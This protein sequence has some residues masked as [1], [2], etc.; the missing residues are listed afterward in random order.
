MASTLK[1]IL[2]LAELTTQRLTD[3]R[4]NW[5]HFLK[6]AGWNYKYAFHDQVLIHAQKP[7]ATACA[8]LEL[9]NKR[10]RRWV[11]KNAEGIAL[12][13]DTHNKLRLRYVFDISD[14]NS[15]YGYEV[16][17]WQLRE[18][19]HSGV[20][21]ALANSFGDL[22][23]PADMP[24]ALIAAAKNAAEDNYAD[25]LAEL[26]TIKV[27]SFLEELDDFNV[28]VEFR[29]T[30]ETSI[31]YMLLTRCGYDA[32]LYLTAEDFPHLYDFNTIPTITLLGTASSDISEML[33]REIER[34]VRSLER[35]EKN[36]G[37]KFAKEKTADNN[38]SED[39]NIQHDTERSVEYGTDIQTGGRLQTAGADLAGGT[40]GDRE[41]RQD[42]QSVSESAPESTLLHADDD[43]Q[44]DDA[45]GGNR[46]DSA[47]AAGGDYERDGDAGRR[48]GGTESHGSDEVGRSEEQH[49]AS[50]G[51]TD[52]PRTDI[53]LNT[54]QGGD[55]AETS[56]PPFVSEELI[57]ELLS[58]D[59]YLKAKRPQIIQYFREN[60]DADA[61]S[62]YIKSVYNDDYSE[63]L[64]LDKQR[65]GYKK[66]EHG[67]CMWE[68]SYL[69]RTSESVFSWDAV[70]EYIAGLI[71]RN[72]YFPTQPLPTLKGVAE[73]MSLF[74]M[75][76]FEMPEAEATPAPRKPAFTVSQQVIDEVLASGGN[77]S[78]SRLRICAYFKKNHRIG[79]TAVFLQ[80]EFGS[81]GKGFYIGA[82]RITARYEPQGIRIAQGRTAI[83]ARESIVVTWEQAAERIRTLLNAGQYMPQEELDRVDEWERQDIAKRIWNLYRDEF[84]N[85]PD[86][87]KAI[88][89][90]YPYPD[91]VEL[92][93]SGLTNHSTVRII[94]DNIRDLIP[95]MEQYPPRHRIYHDPVEVYNAVSDL[96]LPQPEYKAMADFTFAENRRYISDDEIDALLASRGSGISGGK[97]RIYTYFKNPHTDKEK[98]DFL[99][100]EYGTGGT[101]NGGDNT[102]HDSK[103]LSYSR[104]EL[105]KP[106]DK[107]LLPWNKVAKR[108]EKLIADGR[109]LSREALENYPEY[110][111]LILCREIYNFFSH[112]PEEVPRPYQQGEDF[113]SA[114]KTIRPQLDDRQAV[115]QILATMESVL[116]NTA[117][118]DRHYDLMQ[119]AF[120]DLTA[121]DNG[122]YALIGTRNESPYPVQEQD[123]DLGYGHLGN[124]LTVWDR[125]REVDGDYMTIA[126]IDADRTVTFYDKDLP[127][128]IK[129]EIE[130]VAATAELT[131]SQTQDAPVFS[132]P[133]LSKPEQ[134]QEPE[135]V[136]EPEQT[137]NNGR[138]TAELREADEDSA[139]YA[140]Y[141]SIQN[142]D[143]V[144]DEYVKTFRSLE[145]AQAFADTLNELTAQ[146][147]SDLSGQ[148]IE[149]D[150]T[151]YEIDTVDGHLQDD[152]AY[153][154]EVPGIGADE[155]TEPNRTIETVG[156]VRALI[157]RQGKELAPDVLAYRKLQEDYPDRIVGVKVGDRLLF[158]GKDAETA[159]PLLNTRLLQRSI[160]GMGDTAVTGYEYGQWASVGK[161][162]RQHGHGFVFVR[163]DDTGSYE[164]VK[165]LSGKDYIPVGMELEIDGRKF[166][167]DSVNY[168][169]GSVSLRDITFQGSAGYPIFR[170]ESVEFV[171]SY[172]EEQEQA[173]PPASAPTEPT[174]YTS[175]TVAYYP[176]EKNKLP[177]DVE[178]RT[179]RTAEPEPQKAVPERHNFRITDDNLGV[180]GAKTKYQNNVAA[181]RTLMEIELENRLATPEEQEILS[182]YVGWG[183]LPQA[184]D[185]NN[186]AWANEFTELYGLLSPEDYASARATTLNAHYT[187]PVVIR[188]MYQ[189]LENLGFR[190]GNVLEP[191]CGIGN[192][193]GMLP[194]SMQESKLFGVELDSI[195]GRIAK[196][197][198]QKN[199]ISVC[200]FEE[201]NLPD[202][203][204]D[205]A[206]GNVPFGSYKLPDKKYDK[207]NFLIHDYFFAK[208]IDKVRPGGVIA[209]I[210]SKGTLDK[211][212]PS[213]RKYIAQRAELLGAIRLPNNAFKANAGTEVTTD[214][215]F[216]Q[217]RDRIIDT[218]PDWVHLGQTETGI[219]IN[220]YYLDHP[221]MVLGE[222]AF[223]DMM[224][225]NGK[226]TTCKPIEGADLAEQ[227]DA[228]IQ[229]IKGEIS[230]YEL[231]ELLDEEEDKSIP[232][233]P[234]VRNFSYTLVDGEIYFRENSRM[235][236][237]SVS[238]TAESR[239]RGMVAIRDSVRRL[240]E[241]QTEEY[242]DSYIE[243]EQKTLNRLY[244]DFAA[245]YGLLNSRGNNLAFSQD[246]S[247]PLLCSLE[248]LDDHG[249]LKRKADMFVKRTIKANVKVDRVDTASE[250]LAVSLAE[251]ACVDM[252]FMSSLTGKDEATLATELQ[253]VVFLDFNWQSDGS[254]TWRTA[255]DFLSGNVREK[256]K[257]Y[258]QALE[259]M[260]EDAKHIDAIRANVAALERVQPVDL[261]ASEISV[262]LGSTWLPPDV[263][264][265]FMYELLG[266][267]WYAREKIKVH[268]SRHTGEWNVTSK[269]YDRGNPKSETTYGTHRANAYKIIEDTLNQRDVRIFDKVYDD[270]GNERRVLNKKETAIAQAKQELIKQ[271]FKD[272]IWKDAGR[273]ERLTTLYNERFNSLRPR[274]YD[275]S[276]IRFSG[277]NPEIT[278]RKHQIDAIA[279]IIYGGNTLLA[280]EVGAGKTFEMVAAAMES[281]RLGLCSKSMIVVPNHI[282][283]QFAS[284]WLQLYPAANILV[285]T[286]RDFETKNRK[287]FCGRIATGDYD[288][289]IIGHSQFEKIPVSAERQ[290]ATLQRQIDEI[291]EG[292][293][294]AKA[295]RS[296]NYTIKQMEKSRKSLEAKLKKLN[297]QSR[298]DSLVTFEE[299][300]VDR[301]FVDEAH[302]FKNLFLVTKMRNVSGIAQT[303]AQKSSDLFMKCRYLDELTDN[304]GT[305]LATGT[306]IS[307]SMVELYT[308]QRYLQYDALVEAE[309]QHFDAWASTFGETTTAI[310]LAPEGTGYRAKTRFSKFY[311]L[312]ELMS[313]FRCVA[314]IQTAD[315]LNLPV[316]KAN[317]H[318][319]VIKPTELQKEMVAGLAERA[320][321]IRKGDVDPTV[322]N[323]LKITN[324]G[325][326]LA[327]D[328]R[329]INPMLPDDESSKASVCA[330]NVFRIWEQTAQQRSTQ[331]VFCDLSTPKGDG[332]FNVYDDIRDKLIAKGIPPEEIAYIHSANTKAQKMELFAKVRRGD[333]RVLMGS[334]Q[335]MGAGTNVQ[336]RLIALHDL[337]CPW[338]PADLQQRSGR[339]VRQGNQNAEVEIY[340]YVTEG[341][342]D[343]YLY[344]L[345]ENKQKF[346]AQI[347]T[348]KAPVRAADDVDETALS[349]AEIKALATGNPHIIE[350]SNLEMEV[351]KLNLLKSSHMS[352]QYD[353][354]DRLLKHYP[355]SIQQH[356]ERIAGYEADIAR[357]SAN[358]PEDKEVFPPMTVLGTTYTEKADAG[359][360]IIGA[361]HQIQ[362]KNTMP[363]GSYRGF[364]MELSFSPFTG[365]YQLTMK[366][367]LS[368]S[369]TLG[370]DIHGN[371]TRIDNLL[372]GLSDSCE[373]VKQKLAE[374][375]RQ[376]E[377]AKAELGKPFPQEEELAAKN[378][379][380]AEL[381]ALLNLDQKDSVILD[382]DDE[383]EQ[384]T[385]APSRRRSTPDMER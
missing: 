69:S 337:D 321:A 301:I 346:I 38:I 288:A 302:Y 156:F 191:A 81:D 170:S 347:M 316:P 383:P 136:Q 79:E 327:L 385:A 144:E 280:H 62:A 86:E 379:R 253:G 240:I 358:T 354:E 174:Q 53:Q 169:L 142:D 248:I 244:D 265:Q 179:L 371:I 352:Q 60:T 58:S 318:T 50:G 382:G 336:D 287:K 196:Q 158:Y 276:H 209:F 231:D 164:I 115:R 329:L 355:R 183:G 272:W 177:F 247:Y 151:L 228:A 7:Q 331:L 366:G 261:K 100:Q 263:A 153:L 85:I 208:T 98:A 129:D 128:Y 24:S 185:E 357:L 64:V 2:P 324:D 146:A 178:I 241:Y 90:N 32:S 59:N 51:G 145:E 251:R 18:R 66:L 369:V 186:A 360:A 114:P 6:T 14:T 214:I 46:A 101:G 286:E 381:N 181:I 77:D 255:D 94:A 226:E 154:T 220:Q 122:T 199:N 152:T 76:S 119:K 27:D 133:P 343:S 43:R 332:S 279:H 116:D 234:T 250:A 223:D 339:I 70:Q 193:F 31:A 236:P 326:K 315:M 10:F 200:G 37:K 132:T 224:Y 320:E 195:T 103:G 104:G 109:Y 323:M 215:I 89:I 194:D 5:L 368:H 1:F 23:E 348:S 16:R 254:Y 95:L 319:E 192:F 375:Q 201:T 266:T 175:E 147:V 230:E 249:N 367:A 260:P 233:D 40:A 362:D 372:S 93:A 159:S 243:S 125:N 165:E 42:A 83:H 143:Y 374:E 52:T 15:F 74:D 134:E 219:P 56:L 378:K 96:L 45:S 87:R 39:K 317:Y 105:G 140:L 4:S 221:E 333:V 213:V 342:F 139:I 172:V 365:V 9:W 285:A 188:A 211:Q 328:Q 294:E 120:A 277:I 204:F 141:D 84:G 325:R 306:P 274:E 150:G 311:N 190:K 180:G 206:V 269:S 123:Y 229:N 341:T 41:I 335:K 235:L 307:N 25:Y 217:K 157:A 345:V 91:D 47:E 361:C 108:I 364:D 13:D 257:K 65:I 370:S 171:R 99:R 88:S 275:G 161:R 350:K 305:I 30:L 344:Q 340:R 293:R 270:S 11:N 75:G 252:G 258:R 384:D 304:H 126:H 112:L 218:E 334:T 173:A 312:P 35:E 376:M 17:L 308:M 278:L 239:I 322:D 121:Y 20:T 168:A 373:N 8:E 356:K 184:F 189:A 160:D 21:E 167:I 117:D 222:M 238:A 284:E 68:G 227:L 353:L 207:H 19:H 67:L 44:A 262:R 130:R 80:K 106:Y 264:Q 149:I 155:E 380:L 55:E 78:E 291:V 22:N 57:S 3:K 309:L 212:N 232:A 310:E 298:K 198:Y 216:L 73:Q 107:I 299:L 242:P 33:L 82:E 148:R 113:Y 12:I 131:V 282:T 54:E 138:F 210:S 359:K 36:Q 300:G 92:I 268:Y 292:I 237:V 295:A 296:E 135:P 182:R 338:R 71:D 225:G 124:G 245:K 61:R 267:G 256:L 28:Q 281:K 297:D 205:V 72:L 290:R 111:K 29:Q 203:F 377:M 49:P 118:F 197:L 34:T 246:S 176:A 48:D 166:A 271:A 202:S 127:E 163:P 363:I 273:R 349:Y 259:I 110:E 187:S 283:G 137:A 313:M 303:E 63:L 314:D 162:L 289:V 97:L 102:D 26:L 351:G 330:A